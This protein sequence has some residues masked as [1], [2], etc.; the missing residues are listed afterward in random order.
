MFDTNRIRSDFDVEFQLG[1][2]WFLTALNALAERG[3]LIPPGT[4][5]FIADDATFE[6][7][8]VEIV[9]DPP[10]RDLRVEIVISDLLPVT[11]FASISLSDDGSELILENSLTDEPATVPFGVLDGL[12]GTPEL[13]KLQGNNDHEAVIALLAN[14]DLRASPQGGPPLE[15]DE[16]LA[17]GDSANALSFL[18]L[19]QS[20]GIGIPQAALSRFANDIWHSQL[21]DDDGNHPFPDA[22]DRQGD[23]R[24]VSMFVQNGRIRVIL[25]ARAEVDSPLI[26]IIPDPDITITVDL[27]PTIDDGALTFEIDTD[28][29][30]DFGIL[31]DL[32]AALIGGLIGFVIGLFTGNPIGGAIAGAALGV[33]VLEVGEVIVGNII[34]REIQAQID[35]AP[36]P[37]FFKCQNNVVNLATVPDQGQGLNLGILDTLP[38]SVPIYSD[39]PD[40]LHERF[41]L[42]T[43]HFDDFT[44]NTNGFGL[45]GSS[46]SEER[47]LPVD[48]SIVR[49]TSAN[50]ALA[51]LIYQTGD[52]TEHE[53]PLADV[54]ARVAADKVPEPLNVVDSD[55]DDLILRKEEGQLPVA[56]MHPVAIR[57]EE[58]I[59]TEIRF[60]TGL[61]LKTADTIMLQDAGAL[62]LPNLQLIHPANSNPYYRAPPN[63]TEE[64][65]FENLPE[66]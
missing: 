61:E 12:A 34:A 11:V 38:T 66:F 41:V 65:N 9:F 3:L 63:A 19:G 26:D 32:L 62:I 2:G 56:C 14:L 54:L 40:P 51:T 53:L 55:Q 35:G 15:P 23:W 17:R 59:I 49:Q 29:S 10:G 31:G 36:L 18:P 39:N 28:A 47:Y 60:D 20:V 46:E 27:I 42:V 44:L 24:S 33:V 13:V 37:Q 4:I 6:V 7:T 8:E 43:T 21:A 5:P 30:I 45:Q 64:D 50:G 52:G 22:E 57:R 58:T 16:H 25:Q 48:A 1:S